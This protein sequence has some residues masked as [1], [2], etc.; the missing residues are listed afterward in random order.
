MNQTENDPEE[1]Q[2][3]VHWLR[4]FHRSAI[5][6]CINFGIAHFF[7]LIGLVLIAQGR[8]MTSTM[9][10]AYVLAEF[11]SYSITI[12]CHRLFA[13]RTFKATRPLI[14]FLAVCNFF[15]GQHSIWQ[16]LSLCSTK[17]ITL[18][19]TCGEI[20]LMIHP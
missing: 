3:Q 2:V 10:F 13:H 7:G 1:V 8:V 16:C 11:A 17:D 9:I 14:N 19:L 5:G 4:E 18:P 6:M 12:G 15:A 20:D